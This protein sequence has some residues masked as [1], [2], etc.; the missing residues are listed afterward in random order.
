MMKP[1]DYQDSLKA[2]AKRNEM[3]VRDRK[4]GAT[5]AALATKYRITRARCEQICK[6]YGQKE[7]VE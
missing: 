4:A 5:Y 7:A 2:S 1:F 3:I 6:A